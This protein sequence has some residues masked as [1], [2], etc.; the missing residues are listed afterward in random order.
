MGW[1]SR[2]RRLRRKRE[3]PKPSFDGDPFSAL[4]DPQPRRR[5]E[6]A[7]AL[8][9]TDAP[10]RAVDALV[11]ALGDPV[12]F[13]RWQAGR[14]LVTLPREEALRGIRSALQDELPLRRAAAAEALGETTWEEAL[15]LLVDALSDG[16]AGVRVA[17][18]LSLGRLRRPEAVEYLVAYMESEPSPGVRWAIARAL[19]MIGAPE[20]AEMLQQ[21]LSRQDEETQVRRSAAWALGQLGW[22]VT[23]VTGLLAALD[24]PDPQIRWYACLGLG[25]AAQALSHPDSADRELLNQ[26]RN[27]LVQ[28]QEDDADAGEG[29][30]GEAAAQAL[31]QI[32]ASTRRLRKG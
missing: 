10:E 13:V 27:A 6:A 21:C 31:A 7:L 5:W 11:Q 4:A 16:D 1:I 8:Q 30:V 22:D 29:I 15:P 14:S 26:V 24:D 23:A 12:P 3:P 2:L 20:A 17:A 9:L 32:R 25:R 18:A 19:G 28:R